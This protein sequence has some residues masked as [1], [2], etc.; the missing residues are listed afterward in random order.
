MYLIFFRCVK[1]VSIFKPKK[2][3][4]STFSLYILSILTVCVVLFSIWK[5]TY[6]YLLLFSDIL[7]ILILSHSTILSSSFITDSVLLLWILSLRV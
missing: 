5:V 3:N 7:L 2:L 1:L 4:S 6:L